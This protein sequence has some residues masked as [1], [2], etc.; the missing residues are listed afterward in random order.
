MALNAMIADYIYRVNNGLDTDPPIDPKPEEEDEKPDDPP[1]PEEVEPPNDGPGAMTGVAGAL[2][3]R[4]NAIRAAAGL[5]PSLTLE[6][7]LSQAA[8]VQ[9][10]YMASVQ[11]CTHD[12]AGGT[13]PSQRIYAA[14]YPRGG[15]VGENVAAGQSDFGRLM[16]DWMNSP[17]HRANIVR[18]G[19][20]HLGVGYAY[21]PNGT[22]RHYYCVTFGKP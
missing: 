21:R 18:N 16:N 19:W 1:P 3:S 17:G 2:L 22:Y 12:G 5:S 9:A 10:A 14:G 13:S 6:S 4:H 7:R 11:Q 20:T 15:M 8:Q